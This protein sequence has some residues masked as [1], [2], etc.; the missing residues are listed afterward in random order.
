MLLTASLLNAG[1]S[2]A[3]LFSGVALKVEGAF[4]SSLVTL[5]FR[6]VVNDAAQS[7]LMVGATQQRQR[8][9]LLDL[10]SLTCKLKLQKK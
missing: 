9:Y 10:L 3:V 8:Q 7:R 1:V 4:N 6:D 5:H 2:I